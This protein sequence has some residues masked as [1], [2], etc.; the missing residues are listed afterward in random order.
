MFTIIGIKLQTTTKQ[1]RNIIPYPIPADRD[2]PAKI[3]KMKSSVQTVY[4][5]H[6]T[7]LMMLSWVD[8]NGAYFYSTI[9]YTDMNLNENDIWRN[10]QSKNMIIE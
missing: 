9:V 3:N 8:L 6:T 7:A 5:S 10:G 4:N 1:N 2:F